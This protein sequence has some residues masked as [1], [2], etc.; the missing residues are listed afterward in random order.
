MRV[1]MEKS[2]ILSKIKTIKMGKENEKNQM[3]I[4]RGQRNI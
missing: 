1:E 3:K 4:G 2:C